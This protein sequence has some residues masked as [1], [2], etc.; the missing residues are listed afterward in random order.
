MRFSETSKDSQKTISD[1]RGFYCGCLSFIPTNPYFNIFLS[2]CLQF[3]I[4][5]E[6]YNVH[7]TKKHNMDLR[8][9]YMF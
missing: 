6:E 7:Q 8:N 9:F 1:S 5:F 3:L 2:W 4:K